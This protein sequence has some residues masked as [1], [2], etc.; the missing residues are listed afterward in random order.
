MITCLDWTTT[1]TTTIQLSKWKKDSSSSHA[2][3]T[4]IG[5]PSFNFHIRR[6]YLTIQLPQDHERNNINNTST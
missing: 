1:I 3:E 4:K 2:E 5:R 6:R